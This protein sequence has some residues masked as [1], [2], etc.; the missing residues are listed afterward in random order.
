M[1]NVSL[2]GN[3]GLGIDKDAGGNA[4]NIINAPGLVITSVN[5]STGVARPRLS[6]RLS[7]DHRNRVV[8]HRSRSQRLRRGQLYV[9]RATTDANG[10]WQIV[11]PSPDSGCYT[12]FES[13]VVI[14]P[15][16]SS[17]FSRTTCSVNLPTVLRQPS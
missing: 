6:Q 9:G 16:G 7:G 17:E 12:A 8:S 2:Y 5:R 4:T 11:D 13:L 15:I 14:V 10:N 3:G 1:N